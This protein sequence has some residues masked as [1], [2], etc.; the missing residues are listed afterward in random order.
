MMWMLVVLQVFVI[1]VN[2]DG[3][4]GAEEEMLILGES[5]EDHK[6]FM[7]V[8]V[9]VSFSVIEC[10]RVE[11]DSFVFLS[12]VLLCKDGSCGE[13]RSVDL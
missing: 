9:V 5:T 4:G 10:L 8:D 7:V 13:G 1:S 12:I 2:G 11:S 6:Q 3:V